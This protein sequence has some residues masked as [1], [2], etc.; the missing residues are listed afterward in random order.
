M[1]TR[2]KKHKRFLIAGIVV[3]IIAGVLAFTLYTMHTNAVDVKPNNNV[4][5]ALE[6][7]F[8]VVDWQY[9]QEINPD[10]I[11]WVT[12]PGTAIDYP[13]LQAHMDDPEFYLHHDIYKNYNVYGVPYLDASCSQLQFL[14]PNAV[15][16]G[17]HMN[18]GSMF[19]D[20]SNFSDEAYV[21]E[22]LKILIQTPTRKM[23]YTPN[24]VEIVNGTQA[25]KRTEFLDQTDFNT[26]YQEQINN[27]STVLDD[28]IKPVSVISFVTCS[29][30]F[31]KNE[32]TIVIASVAK[33]CDQGDLL[34]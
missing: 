2:S 34:L 32:R 11:G 12:V 29:Y 4:T 21:K 33:S 16:F 1:T 24:C 8:P 3:L 9:W 28:Q 15:V 19:S 7:G 31:S 6:D 5:P 26:W 17:H 23:I 27:A 25:L 18:D 14:S 13:I 10:I 30:N 20:F 22:H